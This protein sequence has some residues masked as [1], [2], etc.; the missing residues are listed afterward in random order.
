MANRALSRRSLRAF[1]VRRVDLERPR[2]LAHVSDGALTSGAGLRGGG[3]SGAAGTRSGGARNTS[4]PSDG[5][6]GAM[7]ENVE[8][9][10][11]H[12]TGETGDRDELEPSE[13]RGRRMS[14]RLKRALL[15]LGT[16]RLM[17]HWNARPGA[18][19]TRRRMR[20]PPGRRSKVKSAWPDKK[21]TRPGEKWK[22]RKPRP[23]L[24][25]MSH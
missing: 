21:H 11:G 22:R 6:T 23:K 18:G 10:D 16:V 9:G 15:R 7:G 14:S 12:E 19:P 4:S 17:A 24:F 25:F 5:S 20:R 13:S 3:V 1:P 2:V 8:N